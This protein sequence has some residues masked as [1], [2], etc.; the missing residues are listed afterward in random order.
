MVST[1]P[2]HVLTLN[3]D[4]Q[5]LFK[6]LLIHAGPTEFIYYWLHRAL[7]LHSLYARYHPGGD[8]GENWWFLQSAP[9]HLPPEAGAI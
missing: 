3:A 7:H 1:L 4:A 2:M 6:L 9:V 8:P 5:G